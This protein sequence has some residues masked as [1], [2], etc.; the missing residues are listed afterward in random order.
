[1]QSYIIQISVVY[2]K[3]SIKGKLNRGCSDF[4]IKTYRPL[5]KSLQCLS[6]ESRF[7]PKCDRSLPESDNYTEK[8][9]KINWMP[10]SSRILSFMYLPHIC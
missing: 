10:E 4:N 8:R 7:N 2:I 1:M 5:V 6:I 3:N 9:G